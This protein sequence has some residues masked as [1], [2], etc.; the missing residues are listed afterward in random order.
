MIPNVPIKIKPASIQQSSSSWFSNS[1]LN[2]Y[3]VFELIYWL[4]NPNDKFTLKNCLL[5][6]FKLTRNKIKSKSIY[7]G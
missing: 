3:I 1:I 2:L 7:N 6:T 5:G 4:R